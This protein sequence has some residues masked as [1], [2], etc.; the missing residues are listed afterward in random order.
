MV[1]DAK[2]RDVDSTLVQ[3]TTRR[4]KFSIS[5]IELI[6]IAAYAC[7]L[8]AIALTT[9][10]EVPEVLAIAWSGHY[11]WAEFWSWMSQAPDPSPLAW[12]IQLPFVLAFGIS[13]LGPRLPALIFAVAS[14]FL[15][16]PLA[17]RAVPK[18][19]WL[20]LLLFMLLPVQWLA[21]TTPPQYEVAVFFPLLAML[22]FFD[23]A[24]RPGYKSATLFAF[25]L[26]ACFYA[27]HHSTLPVFGVMVF[28]LR[29]VARPL[30]RKALWFALSGCLAATLAYIPYYFWFRPQPDPNWLTQPGLSLTTFSTTPPIEW[31][32]VGAAVV[33]LIG[34]IAGAVSSFRI[35][36]GQMRRRLTLFCL[37]GSV[38]LT[39]AFAVAYSLYTQFPFVTCELLYVVPGAAIVFIGACEWLRTESRGLYW[40]LAALAFAVLLICAVADVQY[41]T[42]PKQDLALESRYVAP[43]LTRNSC[44][45]FVSEK[46]SRALFLVFQP[47]LGADECTDFFHHRIVLASHPYV[48]SDQQADAEGF[49]R[50]LGFR[51]VKRIRSGGGEIVVDEGQ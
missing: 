19:R 24:A 40:L 20:A 48:R 5:W 43:E 17:Q 29:F 37:F 39:L 32:L 49:F 23:L 51:E 34:V 22:A 41:A 9:P 27:D 7:G 2:N 25:A 50:G 11:S 16:L 47:Q 6:L 36:P 45:V 8:V 38:V 26:T 18:L 21:I 14:C 30:E 13:R 15:F 4:R 33:I 35:P 31:A 46:F 42:A 3:G 44:V 10:L 28:L 1:I 12:V